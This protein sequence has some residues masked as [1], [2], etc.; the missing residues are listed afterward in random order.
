[1]LTPMVPDNTVSEVTLSNTR[2]VTADFLSKTD[3]DIRVYCLLGEK[4]AISPPLVFKLTFREVNSSHLTT[5]FDMLMIGT[6]KIVQD[7]PL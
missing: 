2:R 5:P 4:T 6:D 7:L 1:M 3:N